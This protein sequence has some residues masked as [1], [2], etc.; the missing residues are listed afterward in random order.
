MSETIPGT[1]Y[2]LLLALRASADRSSDERPGR[3]LTL[4]AVRSFIFETI[5]SPGYAPYFDP[6]VD[7]SLGDGPCWEVYASEA[8]DYSYISGAVAVL[9]FGSPDLTRGTSYR[10]EHAKYTYEPRELC[11]E[12]FR[13]AF[14]WW[15]SQLLPTGP[16]TAASPADDRRAEKH[17]R[18][19]RKGVERALRAERKSA[20]RAPPR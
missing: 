4:A 14:I 10:V 3:D 12:L 1:A 20:R 16:G 6:L 13:L 11:P 17:L 5:T 2:P 8:R 7:S 15:L 18:D 19:C 9:S